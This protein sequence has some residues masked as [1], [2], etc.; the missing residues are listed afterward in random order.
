MNHYAVLLTE[1][2]YCDPFVVYRNLK[3]LLFT[4]QVQALTIVVMHGLPAKTV[5]NDF[6]VS[7][8][9]S[10]TSFDTLRVHVTLVRLT[11]TQFGKLSAIFC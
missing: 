7:S 11:M 8:M 4:T 9:W 3:S 1:K 5:K 10:T 6:E 2:F